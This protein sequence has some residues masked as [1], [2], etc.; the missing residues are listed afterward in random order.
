[1][2]KEKTFVAP[3]S[4]P[5]AQC[6]LDIAKLRDGKLAH[7]NKDEVF[8]L[9]KETEEK[10]WIAVQES[11]FEREVQ[12]ARKGIADAT[13]LAD[14]L[15]EQGND[16]SAD[17][18]ETIDT[19]IEKMLY[20]SKDPKIQEQKNYRL[21]QALYRGI[22]GVRFLL[23]EG[24][25]HIPNM[26]ALKLYEKELSMFNYQLKTSDPMTLQYLFKEITPIEPEAFHT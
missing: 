25:I 16:M 13:K 11:N 8:E 18:R 14:L 20:V 26:R 19:E 22:R 24:L 17:A 23:E 9:G 12:N 2:K 10:I 6:V 21:L 4:D 15:Y 1:M 3:N 7:N 5:L